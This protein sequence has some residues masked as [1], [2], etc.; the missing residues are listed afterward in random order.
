[1]TW[2]T[3]FQGEKLSAYTWNFLWL[4][5]SF[6]AYSPFCWGLRKAPIVSRK[7]P[8]VSIRKN[9]RAHTNK[10]GT[11]SPPPQNPKYTPPL[12]QG[13]LYGHGFSCRTDAFFPG[14]HE[15]GAAISGPRIADKNFT[16]TWIFLKVKN[17]NSK[18]KNSKT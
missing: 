5:L 11:S 17:A 18:Q 1:M 3:C 16:D 15:I 6:L 4:Q 12:K 2:L 7:A 10:I 9:P 13:I 14:V 8:I